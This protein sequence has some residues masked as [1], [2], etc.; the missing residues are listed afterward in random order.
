ML[1]RSCK[2]NRCRDSNELRMYYIYR[3]TKKL[4]HKI[5]YP[6]AKKENSIFGFVFA[7]YLMPRNV[8]KKNF[9][10]KNNVKITFSVKHPFF[11]AL[12]HISGAT[13]K[14]KIL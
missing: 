4:F 1:L 13:W 2:Y 8:G 3:E 14:N 12:N 5:L 11:D 9:V 10:R 7:S 6:F